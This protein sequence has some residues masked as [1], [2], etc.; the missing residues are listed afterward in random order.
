MSDSES[1]GESWTEVLDPESHHTFGHQPCLDLFSQTVCPSSQACL[2]HMRDQHQFDL[3]A[4]VVE[5]NLTHSPLEVIQWINFLRTQRPSVAQLR[6]LVSERPWRQACY[7]K[8][9]LK[10]DPLLMM[11]F[12]E[13]EDEA[14]PGLVGDF[15]AQT[16][17]ASAVPQPVQ[18]TSDLVSFKSQEWCQF[19]K[20]HETLALAL[21]EK[22]ERIQDMLQAMNQM[23]IT[24][25]NLIQGDL[26]TPDPAQS[27]QRTHDESYAGSY[28]HFGIHHEMLS[29]RIRTQ[30]YRDAIEKNARSHIHGREVLDLGCGT[31][32]LSM[33]CAR[34]GA[35]SVIGVDMSDIV[36]QAMEIVH[37]NGLGQQIRLIKGKLEEASL[38]DAQF[39][40]I[41]SE[42]MGYFLLFE[43]MLDSVIMARNKYLRKGGKV[44]PNRCTMHLVGVSDRQRYS[45]TVEYWR[46]V[47]GFKMS[48]MKDP[49]VVEGSVEVVKNEFIAS[50]PALIHELD[51]AT[52]EITDTEFETKF[53]MAILRD[54]ELT[55]VAGYFDSFFDL[56]DEPV[57]FTTGPHGTPTHWK[58]TVFYLKERM[59]VKEGQILTGRIK[60]T[61][62]SNDVRSLHVK[63]TLGDREQIFTVE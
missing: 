7:M 27:D 38:D 17:L 14:M 32:I 36:H 60:V 33:F 31:G 63:L 50:Q 51:L 16:Q 22:E 8:P 62:P 43:G 57:M 29:D 20:A 37:E 49:V 24:A 61:R 9:F 46:D 6:G 28:A 52:C 10:D 4:W 3:K 15:Q 11:D 39:D 35:R 1:E 18:C 44:L 56:E 12:E 13:D 48:C 26:P 41:V 30:A 42:W 23:K 2:T 25:Q 5:L 53:E 55:S 45:E 59:P 40:V 54:C 58:Q 19:L 34:A 47:Y 21:R